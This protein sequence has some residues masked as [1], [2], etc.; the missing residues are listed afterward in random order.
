MSKKL[1]KKSIKKKIKITLKESIKKF[2]HNKEVQ[3]FH[4]LDLIFPKERRIRSLIGGLETSLGTRVW[5]PVAKELAKNNGFTVL[6]EKEFNDSVPVIETALMHKLSDFKTN[7]LLNKDVLCVDHFAATKKYM[8]ENK[9]LTSSYTKI[10]KGEGVDLWLQKNGTEYLIDLK[11]TQ[12]N[13]GSGPKF[14]ENV[15]KWYTYQAL[16]GVKK[17][18]CFIGFPFNPHKKNDFWKK[19]GGKIAPLLQDKEAYVAD[20]FWDMLSGHKNSTEMIFEVFEE[21]GQENFGSEFEDIF[22]NHSD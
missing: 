20:N 22:T 12:V 19:E 4:P 21:L 6:N 14:L 7:K 9:I 10:P 1:S 8:K 2:F 5:E 16:K 13:A 17:T 3:V 18:K 11:T 15:L